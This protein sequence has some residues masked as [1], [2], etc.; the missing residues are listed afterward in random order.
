MEVEKQL[1]DQKLYG[2]SMIVAPF[3]FTVSTF[4][5]TNGEYGVQGGTIMVISLVFWISAFIG[6]FGML[7]NKMPYYTT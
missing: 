6:L 4:F 2:I 7:K 1:L 5:W 3:L